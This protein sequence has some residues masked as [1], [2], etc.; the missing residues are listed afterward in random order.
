MCVLFPVPFSILGVSGEEI[1]C[2][3]GR[4]GQSLWSTNEDH[5]R[6]SS[7][8]SM[9]AEFITPSGHVA[10]QVR[11]EAVG[12]AT[13]ALLLKS[14]T[15]TIRWVEYD[16]RRVVVSILRG[17]SRLRALYTIRPTLPGV[18]DQFI[19]SRAKTY[20]PLTLLYFNSLRIVRIL[21]LSLPQVYFSG[22][23]TGCP[24]RPHSSSPATQRWILNLHL[25]V[26]LHHRPS[27]APTHRPCRFWWST[28]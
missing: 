28:K 1:V 9:Q 14:M 24:Q 5:E 8:Y 21:I 10:H 27:K 3:H 25:R 17:M 6:V 23:T 13:A 11:H 12:E 18:N 26:F 4:C 15:F 16:S 2:G 22:S 19:I 20:T 7:V